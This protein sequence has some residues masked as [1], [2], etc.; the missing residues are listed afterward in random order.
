M[1]L[2]SVGI[3]SPT[4]LLATYITDKKGLEVYVGR[5]RPITDNHPRIEYAG[6]VRKKEITR[7]LPN[8]L[9]FRKTPNITADMVVRQAVEKEHRQLMNFYKEKRVIGFLGPFHKIQR[10]SKEFLVC[11]FH[12]F[13]G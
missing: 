6:W 7:V 13:P 11:S 1:A 4:A 9:Q 10:F 5:A 2:S 12:S 3:A 8:I